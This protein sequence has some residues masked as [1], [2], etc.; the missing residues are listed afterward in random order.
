MSNYMQQGIHMQYGQPMGKEEHG[1][2]YYG[3]PHGYNVDSGIN[4]EHNTAPSSLHGDTENLLTTL[5]QEFSAPGMADMNEQFTTTRRCS[6]NDV[7]IICCLK[8]IY[9]V[10]QGIDR[11][12]KV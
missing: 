10:L 11:L 4:S 6:I 2:M 8:S 1:A 7:S 12:Q 5:D 9:S 3:Q